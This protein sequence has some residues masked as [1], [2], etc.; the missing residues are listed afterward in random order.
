VPL[1]LALFSMAPA[2]V[3]G[4]GAPPLFTAADAADVRLT[5]LHGNSV[6]AQ[7]HWQAICRK[8]SGS[9]EPGT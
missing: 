6:L 8:I 2:A 1:L 7:V 5:P 3:L 4:Q 9:V